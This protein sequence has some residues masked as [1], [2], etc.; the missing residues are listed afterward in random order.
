MTPSEKAERDRLAST[1][2]LTRAQRNAVLDPSYALVIAR[3]IASAVEAQEAKAFASK[4]E[5]I[6]EM[7]RKFGMTRTV[8]TTAVTTEAGIQRFGGTL[9]IPR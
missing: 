4:P 5:D 1:R 7:D 8:S 6:Q 9:E 2:G 3:N